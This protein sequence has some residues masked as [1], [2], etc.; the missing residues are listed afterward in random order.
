MT[1]GWPKIDRASASVPGK[2]TAEIR[3]VFTGGQDFTREL[4]PGDSSANVTGFGRDCAVNLGQIHQ[5]EQDFME[6]QGN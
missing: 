1:A 4:L 5:N 2:L 3:L 6:K